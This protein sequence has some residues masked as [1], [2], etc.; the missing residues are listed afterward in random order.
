MAISH[1]R[2]FLL[3]VVTE[4]GIRRIRAIPGFDT[5]DG[6]VTPMFTPYDEDTHLTDFEVTAYLDHHH[7]E[8]WG[9]AHQFT[10]HTVDL[11]RAEALVRVLRKVE[12][13]MDKAH[14]QFGHP[15]TFHTYLLQV[16]YALRIK[17]FL[18]R[19]DDGQPYPNG[20]HYLTHTAPSIAYWIADQEKTY[21]RTATV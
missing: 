5:R 10:P 20:M 7:D 18:V 15:T 4:Y 14:Q 6:F 12:R 16:A 9:Q 19:K 2:A 3:S 13:G 8:A 21:C 11:R 17:R 1:P